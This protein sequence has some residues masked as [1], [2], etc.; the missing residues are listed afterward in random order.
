[1]RT[2]NPTSISIYI[3]ID[4]EIIVSSLSRIFA[5]KKK[6]RTSFI[7]CAVRLHSILVLLV[8]ENTLFSI[9]LRVVVAKGKY[10][11]IEVFILLYSYNIL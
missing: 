11:Y 10:F 7:I 6:K 2:R 1:M 9:D 5:N 8:K 4:S 3:Y